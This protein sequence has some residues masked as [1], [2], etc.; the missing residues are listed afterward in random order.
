M[1]LSSESEINVKFYL[2]FIVCY[3]E[4]IVIVLVIS[5]FKNTASFAKKNI[6]LYFCLLI[7]L[8]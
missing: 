3:L 1:M 5:M 6:D 8:V 7:I 2:F 4:I